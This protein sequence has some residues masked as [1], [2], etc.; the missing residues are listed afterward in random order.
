MA[1]LKDVWPEGMVIEEGRRKRGKDRQSKNYK[2][3]WLRKR[4]RYAIYIRDMF[5]CWYCERD[6]RFEPPGTLSVDHIQAKEEG[7]TNDET[8]L[9]TACHSCNSRK[10]HATLE[11]FVDSTYQCESIRMQARLPLNYALVDEMLNGKG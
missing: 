1:T 8:N 4:K 10:Q 5:K 3:G 11:Q 9:I 6:C 7:G 2:S